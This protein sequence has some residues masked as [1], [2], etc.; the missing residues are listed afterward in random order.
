MIV[1]QY[2]VNFETVGVV[3][4]VEHELFAQVQVPIF[5]QSDEFF[6]WAHLHWSAVLTVT[7]EAMASMDIRMDAD[8]IW[9]I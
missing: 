2:E 1:V 9:K 8:F 4:E 6:T 5:K 7:E 3:V